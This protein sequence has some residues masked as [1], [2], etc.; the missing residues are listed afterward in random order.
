MRRSTFL[1]VRC[2]CR[3]IF[4][5]SVFTIGWLIVWSIVFAT[6]NF[7]GINGGGW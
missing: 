6:W 7:Y 5:L 3:W 4:W 2:A 1:K